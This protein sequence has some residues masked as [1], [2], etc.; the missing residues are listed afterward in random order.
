MFA[1]TSLAVRLT[2]TGR[3]SN[4][5][6]TLT[7]ILNSFPDLL[8]SGLL[9]KKPALTQKVSRIVSACIRHK[10]L[11][12]TDMAIWN[13]HKRYWTEEGATLIMTI[14]SCLLTLAKYQ[15]DSASPQDE[16]THLSLVERAVDLADVM[17]RYINR[18]K[19]QQSSYRVSTP[20][21]FSYRCFSQQFNHKFFAAWEWIVGGQ[22]DLVKIAEQV[23]DNTTVKTIASIHEGLKLVLIPYGH[24]YEVDL[25]RDYPYLFSAEA[26]EIDPTDE[27]DATVRSS[28]SAIMQM[29]RTPKLTPLEKLIQG[30]G[31]EPILKAL[32]NG[33]SYLD[34]AEHLAKHGVDLPIKELRDHFEPLHQE[35]A[36]IAN[37]FFPETDYLSILSEMIESDSRQSK[38]LILVEGAMSLADLCAE[39][40]QQPE[41][42]VVEEDPVPVDSPSTTPP[43]W[44]NKPALITALVAVTLLGVMGLVEVGY[45]LG[46]F[47]LAMTSL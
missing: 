11:L 17:C 46:I 29:S 24:A 47:Q 4:A 26:R 32:D 20:P 38:S 28:I 5:S 43:F 41:L 7:D 37:D 13:E 39:L 22:R 34:I 33:Y 18:V 30:G 36:A 25:E 44:S 2:Q 27:M 8:E 31:E 12:S 6:Y 9:E 3:I 42:E 14:L 16:L 45:L 19:P 21:Q 1:A 23:C 15:E 10:L 40:D 35:I